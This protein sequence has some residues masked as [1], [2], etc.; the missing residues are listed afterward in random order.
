MVEE[1][2]GQQEV[3]GNGLQGAPGQR[4]RFEQAFEKA[5]EK[6]LEGP[7]RINGFL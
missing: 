7:G 3:L 5:S 2:G 1:G 4:E 6:D